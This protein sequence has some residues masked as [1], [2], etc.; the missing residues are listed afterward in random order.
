MKAKPA[1]VARVNDGSGAFPRIP[2]T[3]RR[4]AIVFPIERSDGKSFL[5]TDVIGFYARYSLDG[6][7]HIDPLGKDPNAAYT[8]FQQ[9]EGDVARMRQGLEPIHKPEP[10]AEPEP[11]APEKDRSLRTCAS[12][13]KANIVAMGKKKA[14]IYAYTRA[15]DDLV[16]RFP[17][18]SIDEI[19]R[20]DVIT[21]M[22][23]LRTN[24]KKRTGDPEHTLRNRLRNLTVFFHSFGVKIPLAMREMKKPM[25]SRPTRYSL[26]F[27]NK[28]L[29][30]AE[31]Q[32][33]DLIHFFLNTG[34]RDEE[35]AFAKWSDIDFAKGSINVHA[36]PE[37]NW[38][39]KDGEARTQDIVLQ[40]KFLKRMKNRMERT[41]QK[42]CDLIFPQVRKEKPDMHLIK[43]VQRV[44]KRAGITDKRITLHSF[45]RTFGSIVAK[46]YG[47]E[48]ARIW[49]GHADIQ[50]TQAYIAADE[51]T[52]EASRKKV[53]NMFA[54][55]GD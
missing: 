9:I 53:K 49:L 46:E 39:P 32:E 13:F 4:R 22:S 23:F 48:Q 1:L 44:S 33:K 6:K 15:V 37:F 10:I 52:T 3:I 40:D 2:V 14:T 8:Q 43:I 29:Q 19:T 30:H 12:Q 20:Q 25:R 27:I 26:E 28:L 16:A 54:G 31:E 42:P 51:L 50:T 41:N 18:K 7:A 55:V 38:T 5:P 17:G 21:Y 45:R 36:K 47:L 11:V 35:V 34:F 24:I